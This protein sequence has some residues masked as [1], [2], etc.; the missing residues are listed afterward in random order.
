MCVCQRT[1]SAQRACARLKALGPS[2]A[3]EPDLP[4][5]ATPDPPPTSTTPSK[6]R[7]LT[8]LLRHSSP[9]RTLYYYTIRHTISP[10]TFHSPHGASHRQGA[11]ASPPPAPE[12]TG[13]PSD[14][15]PAAFVPPRQQPT[16]PL[17]FAGFQSSSRRPTF[18]TVVT[19]HI[20]A[21]GRP[22]RAEARVSSFTAGTEGGKAQTLMTH[23]DVHAA[24][25]VHSC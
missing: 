7:R 16:N 25:S 6:T 23:T 17:Y 3:S 12:S 21:A 10:P 5:R 13:T 11:R 19:T 20:H 24:A 8:A 2:T 18:A 4:Q 22:T 9:P 1:A 14:W 15:P